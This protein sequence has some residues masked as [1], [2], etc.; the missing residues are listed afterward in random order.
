MGEQFID[1]F[2]AGAY[3]LNARLSQA[4]AD[5]SLA[6]FFYLVAACGIVVS[7]L[8]SAVQGPSDLWIRHLAAV[9]VASILIELP[10]RFDLAPLTYAAPG[11]VESVVGTR[12]GAAPHLTYAVERLGAALNERVRSLLHDRPRLAIPAVAAQVTDIASDPAVLSDPQLKA[13]LQ[14]WRDQI[15]PHLLLQQPQLA[16]GLRQQGLLADLLDPAPPDPRWVGPEVAQRGAAVR[17]ALASSNVNLPALVADLEPLQR[18]VADA[19]G[20]DAW[21]LTPDA[22]SV[23]LRLVSRPPPT[24]DPPSLASADYYDAILHGTDL[25]MSMLGALAQGNR[26]SN[27]ARIDEL[28]ELL[29]RSILYAAGVSY[30]SDERHLVTIGSLC[31]RLGDAACAASQSPLVRA[32]QSLRVA[33]PDPYNTASSIT[34]L[35]QP[36]ATLLLAITSLILD[37]LSSIVVAVLPFLLGVGKAIAILMSVVGVWMLLWPGRLREAIGWMVLPIAFV[38]LWAI[39]FGLWSDVE[40]FLSAIASTVGHSDS[41][42]LSAGRI[43]SIAISLGYLGLPAM[44]ASVLS[45]NAWRALDHASG[46]LESALLTAWRTRHAMLSF[47]R[48]WLA[49]S[50]L[51]RRWNQRVY[52]AVGLGTLRAGRAASAPRARRSNG[53]G[54][55]TPAAARP[56]RRSPAAAPRRSTAPQPGQV[57]LD[58]DD[59][60]QA[61]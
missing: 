51:A 38:S 11:Q 21:A 52:R 60:G 18:D 2:A 43:M 34:L 57:R 35:K 23:Q 50:P 32:S 42:S 40:S 7:I 61:R 20:A 47:S 17:A 8:R 39:L 25:S 12:T 37:A 5:P 13:N 4:L 31:Q 33:S 28:H 36:I 59:P 3:G 44:A 19:A 26:W 29:G 46:H 9:A 49:N 30:L 6:W 56:V 54:G 48:R 10:H 55:A 22:A 1:L 24:P 53:S 16:I 45:G 58:L 15:V 41:G 27:V 14:I